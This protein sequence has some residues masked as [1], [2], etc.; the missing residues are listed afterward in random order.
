M[1]NLEE[2][3]R[4]THRAL[5]EAARA[6]DRTTRGLA[7]QAL[8]LAAFWAGCYA[9]AIRHGR[10]S[11]ARLEGTGE[12]YLLGTSHWIVALTHAFIGEFEPALAG[13]ARLR[14]VGDA[15]GEPRLRSSAAWTEGAIHAWM[16]DPDPAI[17]ACGRGLELAPDRVSWASAAGW[18]GYA[19]LEKGEAGRAASFLERAVAQFAEFG[20]PHA[21][22]GFACWLA[23]AYLLEGRP[24]AAQAVAVESLQ[25]TQRIRSPHGIGGAYQALGR[26]ARARGALQE[27]VAYYTKA[28]ATFAACDARFE[29]GRTHLILAELAWAQGDAD[30][31]NIHTREADVLFRRLQVPRYVERAEALAKDL[32]SAA[33]R[34]ARHGDGWADS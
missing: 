26:I 15:A 8:A 32:A 14:A 30:T 13:V 18:L 7:H 16:G 27:S 23:E 11:V 25:I 1:G 21:Q 17:V 34:A 24:E 12:P 3:A 29:V 19:H 33:Q 22:G 5:D 10:E 2:G 4:A 28:L 9:E 20:M 31:A 6:G